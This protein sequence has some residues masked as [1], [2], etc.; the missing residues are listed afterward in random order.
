MTSKTR[1][2]LIKERIKQLES[3]LYYEE[4]PGVHTY[5]QCSCGRTSTRAGVCTLCLK[6]SIAK[7]NLELKE[8]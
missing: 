2:K 4:F 7:L 5:T 6:E 3:D 1:K 8:K